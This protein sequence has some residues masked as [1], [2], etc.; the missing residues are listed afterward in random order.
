MVESWT[1]TLI[2]WQKQRQLKVS[3][4][5][6][7]HADGSIIKASKKCCH[8]FSNIVNANIQLSAQTEIVVGK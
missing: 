6:H 3:F 2:G 1:T 7:P 8:S 5:W 4:P